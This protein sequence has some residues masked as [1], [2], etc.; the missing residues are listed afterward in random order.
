M[1]KQIL[2]CLIG[3]FAISPLCA[4]RLEAFSTDHGEFIE[5]FISKLEYG[6]AVNKDEMEMLRTLW[7]GG[8]LMVGEKDLIIQQVNSMVEL[9]YGLAA[10]I[11]TYAKIITLIKSGD[12]YVELT[13]A[14]FQ[15]VMEEALDKLNN[16]ETMTFLDRL[17]NYIPQGYLK[18]L[19]R[20]YWK[21]YDQ[22]PILSI[23]SESA[24]D[25]TFAPLLKFEGADLQY[26]SL[27]DSMILYNTSGTY[28][29]LT[30]TLTGTDGRVDWIKVGLS[31]EDVYAEVLSYSLD[32]NK[33]TFEADS[34]R[35]FY[36][37]L[38]KEPLYGYFIDRNI[39]IRDSASS[40]YPYFESYSGKVI[41]E[42][43]IPNV[44]Y[45]GG[46]TLKGTTIIGSAYDPT[47]HVPMGDG[48]LPGEVMEANLEEWEQS[49]RNA[50]IDIK[51][52]DRYVLKMVGETFDL[53]QEEVTGVNAATTIFT[54]D[55]DSISHP[56]LDL[57]YSVDNRLIVLKKPSRGAYSHRPYSSSYHDFYFYFETLIWDVETDSVRFTSLLN[58]ENKMSAIESFDYFKESRFNQAKHVLRFNP[59]GAIYRFALQYKDYPITPE[60]IIKSFDKKYNMDSQLEAFRQS[61]PSLES[62]GYITYDKDR[63]VIIPQ[64]K[65]FKW[66]LAARGK[67]DYDALQII[68]RVDTGDH[69]Y[70]NLKS[71]ELIVRG[72]P[73]FAFSDSQYVVVQP[74]KNEVFVGKDRSLRFGGNI[75]AG[76]L[77]LYANKEQN[78]TFDY[79]TF[80][81]I[82]DSVDA[83]KFQVVRNPP[84]EYELSPLEQALSNT[85][86][87]NVSGT[88]HIDDPN[89][90]S[91]KESTSLY[92]VFDSYQ[93]SYIYWDKP[94]I[95][96]G[97]YHRDSMYFAVYPFV[98]DSLDTFKEQGLLFAGEFFSSEIFPIIE[99]TLTVMP[100]FTL[101][102]HVESPEEGYNIFDYKGKFYNELILD[103]SGLHGRGKLEHGGLFVNSDSIIFQFDS[104]MAYVDSFQLDQGY[105]NGSYFPQLEGMQAYYTWYPKTDQVVFSTVEVEDDSTEPAPIN[106][107]NGEAEFFGEL[108]ITEDGLIGNGKLRLSE[109]EVNGENIV[110]KERD[111]EAVGASFV[112]IDTLDPDIAYFEAR[113]VNV[114]YDVDRHEASFAPK[115]DRIVPSSFDQQQYLTSLNIG[116]YSRE[117]RELQLEGGSDQAGDNYFQWMDANSD[118]LMFFAQQAL[119]RLDEKEIDISGVPNLVVADAI[120]TPKDLVLSIMENGLIDTL[121]DATIEADK[122]QKDHYLYEATISI[123]SATSYTGSAKYD[124]IEVEGNRQFIDFEN[125]EVI[126]NQTTYAIGK[127]G[128]DEDFYLTDRILFEGTAELN[129]KNR[130]LRFDGE[131]K[132]ES[133]NP[134]FEEEWFP[135]ERTTVNPDSVFIPIDTYMTND[136]GDE[137]IS[138][139][140]YVPP[141]GEFYS[142]FLQPKIDA[143]D[144]ELLLASGGLTVDRKTKAFRI[145]P[146]DKIKNRTYRGATVTFDDKNNIITSKGYLDFPFN[147]PNKTVSVDMVGAWAENIGDASINTDLVLGINMDVIPEGP[148]GE[149]VSNFHFFT[150]N[151]KDIDFLSRP[152]LENI[153]ELL[154][155][156]KRD[157]NATNDFVDH[158]HDALIYT[159]I[160]LASRLPYTFLISNV[161]FDFDPDQ[162]SLYSNGPIGLIGI[163]G[164][165]VNKMIKARILYQIGEDPPFKDRQPDKITL[166][167]EVDEYNWAYFHFEGDVVRT[168]AP[169]DNYNVPIL[170]ESEKQ[171]GTNGFRFELASIEEA[172]NFKRSMDQRGQ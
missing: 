34:V 57:S 154:D 82:C 160:D 142:S 99:D 93:N 19:Q 96:N 23:S 130:F 55:G 67:K 108:K 125:I 145:G 53:S 155:K 29:F 75:A 58:K 132:I 114:K 120:I 45:Q 36:K 135:F 38:I 107:F 5:S 43:W 49:N 128:S 159:D 14:D 149:L 76:K 21:L 79:E 152:L 161:D 60:N 133:D 62:A 27:D 89:N 20:F 143:E 106:V 33:G 3:F 100:D 111:F 126:N 151:R 103:G 37:S 90:K 87:E 68:S 150:V 98:L 95:Q 70:I 10:N 54:S 17:Y 110:M 163:G 166:Y 115:S 69:A 122:I 170:E 129:A 8:G 144:P 165:P 22:S 84:Q 146:E 44:K 13:L 127:V 137:V 47:K 6:G 148:L 88:I 42:D 102:F 97:V 119:Y 56:G 59:V 40:Q 71:Q 109:V 35:F 156:G 61:L 78:F 32:V 123:A 31:S 52:T 168:V 112:I 4:Q 7:M 2:L 91:G 104:V 164:K 117:E 140:M 113:D 16:K 80:K 24:N 9:K 141:L 63:D 51:G 65:L 85:V 131:V 66:T 25:T 46:F 157:D 83:I 139:L 167:L 28:N 147:F 86:F 172:Q 48:E 15:G 77:N 92:P 74:L 105:H 41:I 94:E 134:V 116:E 138:G 64:P 12:N 158:V 50:R 72:V 121:K 18:K 136:D 171:K 39:G 30:Q 1:N 169:Y 81:I 118:T 73:Y 162:G 124:Y 101:G 26:V 11:A 153:S